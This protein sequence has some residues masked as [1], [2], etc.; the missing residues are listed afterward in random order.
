MI[1]SGGLLLGTGLVVR[2]NYWLLR[3]LGL[4]LNMLS[5]LPLIIKGEWHSAERAIKYFM[6]QAMA[7]QV[8]ILGVIFLKRSYLFNIF[9][10]IA[11]SLKLG[12]APF[13]FWYAT[14]AQGLTWGQNIM[15]IVIQKI[16]PLHLMFS[17]LSS[18]SSLVTILILSSCIV[19]GLGG[20]NQSQLRKVIAYSS[21]NHISWTVAGM[22]RSRW[23]WLKYYFVY[24]YM[25]IY[26][27]YQLIV[28]NVINI[29]DLSKVVGTGVIISISASLLRLG[30]LPPFLGF[31][32]KLSVIHIL[33]DSVLYGLAVFLSVFTLI[34]LYFYTRLTWTF[35]GLTRSKL[36]MGGLQ[37]GVGSAVVNGLGLGVTIYLFLV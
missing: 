25:S 2:S 30:G 20:L 22:L 8:F 32:P 5:F 29:N 36:F 18:S 21:I 19:G 6:V 3:W 23:L 14:V 27:I 37:L 7:R 1:F 4:E 17:G 33:N 10:L 31:I 9:V 35:I 34:S 12:I 28:L 16:G 15:L 11:L 13:H 26:L 24:C